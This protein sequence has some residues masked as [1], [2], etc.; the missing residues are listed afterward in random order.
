M[1]ALVWTLSHHFSHIKLQFLVDSGT[2]WLGSSSADAGVAYRP[3]R[4][5]SNGGGLTVQVAT[6]FR[7]Q[8][9]T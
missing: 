2:L 6:N 8:I 4:V 9:P 7:R 3:M 1:D 5:D